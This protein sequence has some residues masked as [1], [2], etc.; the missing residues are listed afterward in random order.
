MWVE[1]FKSV[2][3]AA[4]AMVSLWGVIRILES[5]RRMGKKRKEKPFAEIR[6][7]VSAVESELGKMSAGMGHLEEAVT[8]VQRELLNQFYREYVERK[9]T[10]SLAM[11]Q[12][13]QGLYNQY[14]QN[15]KH[16]HL[17]SDYL[18]RLL[19]LPVESENGK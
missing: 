14:V 3:V 12:A 19:A 4:G 17:A 8:L 2:G 9:Q 11:K 16:N 10:C 18:E 5:L 1:I 6:D 15:G 7:S 13:I